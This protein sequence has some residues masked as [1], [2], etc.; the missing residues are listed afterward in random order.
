MIDLD[1]DYW[2][3]NARWRLQTEWR[4]GQLNLS[5]G[6]AGDRQPDLRQGFENFV[7]SPLN[8]SLG[9]PGRLKPDET[10]RA[11]TLDAYLRAS[12]QR[13][14]WTLEGGLRRVNARYSSDEVFLANGNQSGATRFS[15]CLPV[16]GVRWQLA[17]QL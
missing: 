16:V 2:G 17:P 6:L 4:S 9:V 14:D 5:A 11:T 10:N 1:R 7:G 3:F 13:E 8:Q 15:G 12:W